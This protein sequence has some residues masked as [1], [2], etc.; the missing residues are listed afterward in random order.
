MMAVV[1]G[2]TVVERKPQS[3]TEA[4]SEPDPG[5]MDGVAVRG[6][7]EAER[8]GYLI[9]DLGGPGRRDERERRNSRY[10]G[11][12][13]HFVLQTQLPMW[14]T[15]ARTVPRRPTRRIGRT[16]AARRVRETPHRPPGVTVR[17]HP[18]GH[19]GASP[20]PPV[21]GEQGQHQDEREQRENQPG[22]DHPCL[23]PLSSVSIHFLVCRAFSSPGIDTPQD[24]FDG[25]DTCGQGAWHESW[26]TASQPI[27][28]VW[29]AGLTGRGPAHSHGFDGRARFGSMA[30]VG[31]FVWCRAG[32]ATPAWFS[33]WVSTAPPRGHPRCS[34]SCRGSLD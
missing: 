1:V 5:S 18:S 26:M 6:Q 14:R 15:D 20:D 33:S 12:S 10:C 28:A 16:A 25:V 27:H 21:Q 3:D 17:V 2:I 29:R 22:S 8:G 7:P 34:H 32:Q 24:S 30:P 31:K 4:E 13:L 9:D 23:G 19:S 11:Q